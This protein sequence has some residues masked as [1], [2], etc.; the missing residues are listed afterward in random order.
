LNDISEAYENRRFAP[1]LTASELNRLHETYAGTYWQEIA[2]RTVLLGANYTI[3]ILSTWWLA[4]GCAAYTA[5]QK[6]MG[7]KSKMDAPE[8]EDSGNGVQIA[9]QA[10]D[11]P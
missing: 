4:I 7:D 8:A 6:M 1:K 3:I 2:T 10:E 5:M 9:V 11:S